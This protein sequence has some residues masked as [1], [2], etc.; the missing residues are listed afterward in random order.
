MSV[1]IMSVKFMSV[2]NKVRKKYW[3]ISVRFFGISDLRSVNNCL[4]ITEL[5]AMNQKQLSWILKMINNL[6]FIVC[7][8]QTIPQ[9]EIGA[10]SPENIEFSVN[11]RASIIMSVNNCVRDNYIVRDNYV[12]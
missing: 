3:S 10:Y 9:G 7:L 1:K 2:N 8:P 11:C 6:L 4:K 5:V 12:R